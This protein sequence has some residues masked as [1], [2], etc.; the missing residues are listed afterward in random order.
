MRISD[1]S[2][3]VCSSDLRRTR[4]R[5]TSA[6]KQARVGPRRRAWGEEAPS[7]QHRQRAVDILQP[8]RLPVEAAVD[9]PRQCGPVARLAQRVEFAPPPEPQ[10]HKHR[11]ILL[12]GKLGM[13]DEI[14][15]KVAAHIGIIGPASD[16]DQPAPAVEEAVARLAVTEIGT[17][18]IRSDERRVGKACVST[19]RSRWAPYH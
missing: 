7:R 4:Q 16:L 2:S 17:P 9:P 15:A 1:W 10:R 5:R 8:L 3:D 6:T 11:S 18:L 14:K 19:C 13:V 12:F